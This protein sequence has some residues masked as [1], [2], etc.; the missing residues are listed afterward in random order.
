MRRALTGEFQRSYE[1]LIAEIPDSNGSGY[2]GSAR[3][4][5]VGIITD[6]F[7]YEMFE[8]ALDLDYLSMDTYSEQLDSN[9]YDFVLYIS[10]WHGMYGSEEYGGSEGVN[11]A[12]LV[13]AAARAK[14]I[15]TVFYSIEDPP[16]YAL[17]IGIAKAADFI[18]TS[19]E[20]VVGDYIR[21]TGNA[22][23]FVLKYGINPSIHNPIGFLN[24]HRNKEYPFR[25]CVVFAG[26]WW[27]IKYPR[28]TKEM[29][30][31]FKGVLD[32][33]SKTVLAID[34]NSR[35]N[36]P[37][38]QYPEEYQQ[39][40]TEA[41]EYRKLQKVCK[42][43]D[44]S[45]CFNSVTNSKTMCA[46][47][48]FE[49]QALGV[50]IIS[51]YARSVSIDFPGIFI[52]LE[53]DEVSRICDGY[54]EEEIICMQL[55]GIRDM[56][57]GNTIYDRVNQ[58]M[59]CIGRPTAYEE[60]TVYVVCKYKTPSIK[61][62]FDKQYYQNKKLLTIE[63]AMKEALPDDGFCIHFDDRDYDPNYIEDL[64]NA[65]KFV[66]VDYTYYGDWN[67]LEGLY[68]YVHMDETVQDAMYNLSR[69]S[70]D[71]IHG[72]GESTDRTGFGILSPDNH[73]DSSSVEKELAVIVPV[74]NNGRFLE[75]RGFRSLRRSSVFD[76][77]NIILVDD[78]STD[79]ITKDVVRRLAERYDNVTEY[80]FP[81]GGSGSAS[82]PRNKG[83]EIAKEQ[84][85]TYLDPDNE[86]INDGYAKLLAA[87]K[88]N[89]EASFVMGGTDKVTAES[90]YI[91]IYRLAEERIDDTRE[92]LIR[93]KFLPLSNQSM[94]FKKSFLVD[95]ELG[96][97]EGA[98]GEDTLFFLDVCAV[99]N[100]KAYAL[101]E[102]VFIY[103]ANRP[104]S[105]VN[106]INKDFF[107]MSLLCERATAKLLKG[108]GLL[109]EYNRIRLETFVKG[110]YIE[111]MKLADISE[112]KGCIDITAEILSLYEE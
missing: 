28:R 64:V 21:D 17:Y 15:T 25:D 36:H 85:I 30:E 41:I 73:N 45:L 32:S 44:F 8:A 16:N 69:I 98:I 110:W 63:E 56:Y 77:M 78:G 70:F 12:V 61:H 95:N 31:I 68:S 99:P 81:E 9:D 4:P 35:L 84:Y 66:N 38:Y 43:F 94:L 50:L 57:S 87:A 39:Y 90:D 112:L 96:F 40:V 53:S 62:A 20:E 11:N 47:R 109:Q 58:I 46:M 104:G 59:T 76:R 105:A 51:N 67:S 48:V 86:A 60:K 111:K 83:L 103:Y 106:N 33:E 10:C 102:V 26:T 107:E 91:P 55:A 18:Y 29:R 72:G 42:L 80:C 23:V 2:Y 93:R 37:D 14:G 22:N 108:R 6:E 54:S 3:R 27:N 89:E 5:H 34:R 71:Q 65:H 79:S 101:S 52:G 13:L 100:V 49:M 88:N 7:T 75:G 19:C 74:Y 24:K 82:R 97:I 92:Y 1:G